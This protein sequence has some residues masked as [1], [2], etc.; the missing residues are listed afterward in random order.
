VTGYWQQIEVPP[1]PVAIIGVDLGQTMD[2][3]AISVVEQLLTTGKPTYEVRHLERVRGKPY[4]DVARDLAMLVTRMRRERP[5]LNLTLVYDRTGV[6]IGVGDILDEA[7]IDAP[8]VP[9][10]IHGGQK[11]TRDG[12]IMKVPKADLVSAIAI[13]LQD[14]RLR[15]APTLALASTLVKEMTTFRVTHNPNTAHESFAAWRENDHD[16]L[17]LSVSM[18]VWLGERDS[19]RFEFMEANSDLGI[20]L[21]AFGLAPF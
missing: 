11:V 13:T 12:S 16:D 1:A 4:T 21:S 17:L 20:A 14:R 6:G 3:T 2:Y 9:I 5:R 19:G 15:T 8:L 18:A 10:L 7:G